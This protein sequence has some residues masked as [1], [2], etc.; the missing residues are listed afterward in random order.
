MD[1]TGRKYT[2]QLRPDAFWS[3]GKP[4]RASEF[5]ASWNRVLDP[6][7][8]SPVSGDLRLIVG[9]AEII[10]G[11]LPPSS[12]GVTAASDSVLIVTL[13]QPAP[14]FPQLLAHSAT[15]PVYS[16]S[17]ARSHDPETWVS[18]GPYTLSRWRPGTSVELS[19]NAA[20]W[21]HANVKVERVSYQISPD[22][23]SQFAA[24]RAGHL[25][26]T[27]TVPPNAIASIREERPQELIIAP[28]LATAYYGLNLASPSLNGNLLLRK[29]LSMAIDRRRLVAAL[30][31]GQTAAYGLVPPGTWNYDPQRWEW[32]TLSDSDRIAEARRLYTEAGYSTARLRL[33]LLI[34]SNPSIKQTAIMIA[35][36]WREE[37]G[38]ETTLAE[39]EFRVFLQSRHNKDKWDVVRMAWN[40]DYNDASNFLDIFRTDS[41]NN[42]TG[43]ANRA[44]DNLMDG[45][46]SAPDP[47]IRRRLLEN[48]ERM[49]LADYPGIPLY[50]FVSKRLVKPYVLGVKP[51]ALDR[52]GSKTLV[53]LP[54]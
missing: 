12:L 24:Y 25:D 20:Y 2:F 26:I 17:S 32:E 51:N 30:G 44:Y 22:Q 4:V 52:V 15:F 13:V 48:A 35:A 8:G 21:D 11:K 28:Y 41:P 16:D 23:Y 27:D 33:R 53:V 18:N 34:N 14:Y 36:M 5:V 3:N 38:V 29:A 42:D 45:A 9:A 19:R 37:L 7:Q 1:P 49:V 39:E 43:Y 10:K 6:K 46:T 54:H 40:A 31:L 47:A 50:F